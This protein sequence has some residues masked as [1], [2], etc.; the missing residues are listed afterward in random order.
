MQELWNEDLHWQ[1]RRGMELGHA[2]CTCE[3]HYHSLWGALRIAGVNNSLKGEEPLLASLVLP[4]LRDDARVMIGGSADPGVLCAIGRI[5]APRMPAMTIIDRC[6]APLALI[7][8]FVEG[9]GLECRTLNLDLLDLD[10]REQWDQI[11]RASCRERVYDD[12]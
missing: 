1:A 2:Y 9:K 4:F 11:G 10:E 3:G 7:R 5:Y 6:K 12:V 8:E